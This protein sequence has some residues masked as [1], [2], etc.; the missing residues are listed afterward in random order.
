MS[1]ENV[2][3][4]EPAEI[5]IGETLRWVRE[6]AGHPAS[7]WALTYS[8]RGA[9][10]G[11]DAEAEADGDAHAVTV[12]AAKTAEMS[13]G[14]YYWQAWAVKGD[15]KHVAASGQA[16]A[17]RGLAAV[18]AETAVDERSRVKKTLDAIDDLLAGRAVADVHMYMIGNR[19]LMK[20]PVGDLLGL[21]KYYASLYAGERR[22]A[23]VKG[24]GTLF[25]TINVRFDPS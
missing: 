6:F 1:E 9:G 20:I 17:K 21:R 3:G 13:P 10:K 5:V 19:Q 22:R 2:P 12:P 16:R 8:F 18:S 23:R 7:E 24:G 15:E 25:Q 4:V 11:F 14:V